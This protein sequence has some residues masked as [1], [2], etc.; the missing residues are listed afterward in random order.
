MRQYDIMR[1]PITILIAACACALAAGVGISSLALIRRVE[2][3]AGSDDDPQG[4]FHFEGGRVV[5]T[6]D[7]SL[8]ASATGDLSYYFVVYPEGSG[9]D[10]PQLTMEFLKDGAPIGKASPELPA[11][12]KDGR[13]P[14]I[15]G[16][17]MANFSPGH[18][19][20]RT[21]VKQGASIAEERTTFSI[22]P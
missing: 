2:R 21:T 16:L 5:P 4:P 19:E 14:Y 10:R 15:A 1:L 6:L 18:Y 22:H 20:L 13:I 3:Q 8:E 11:A 12:G 17:P 9:A 7:D